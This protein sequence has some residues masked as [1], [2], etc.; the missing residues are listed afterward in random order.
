MLLAKGLNL[1]VQAAHPEQFGA[2]AWILPSLTSLAGGKEQAALLLIALSLLVGFIKGRWVLV[3]SVQ[4]T[5]TRIL[6]QP[7][8]LKFSQIY[9][10]SYYFLILG[11]MGLGF[12]IKFLPLAA[13]FKGMVDVAV[14]SA[15]INGAILYFRCALV[16]PRA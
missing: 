9:A 1:L 15:L 13:D 10:K 7:A 8:P 16:K 4:R 5:V 11:M 3:K 12:L 6:S 14:G 2:K